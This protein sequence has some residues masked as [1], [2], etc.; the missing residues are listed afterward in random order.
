MIQENEPRSHIIGFLRY[1]ETILEI[2][3]PLVNDKVPE[4]INYL[5]QGI[6]KRCTLVGYADNAPYYRIEEII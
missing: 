6:R 4:H 1:E 3:I 5:I 2:R